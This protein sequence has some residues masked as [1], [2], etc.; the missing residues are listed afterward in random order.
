M[1]NHTPRFKARLGIF[2]AVG[3]LIFVTAIFIIGKQQNLF[4]PVFKISTNFL[5]VSGLQVGNNI[6]FSGINVGIVDNIKII[7]DSTV[8]VDMLVRKDVQQFIKADS[9]ASIGS[10]GIIGDRIIIITQGSTDSPLA[11]DGQHI[12]SKEPIETDEIMKSLKSSAE[13]AEV[14]TVQLAEIMMNINNGQG[15]LGRLIQD[16]VIAENVNMTIE[17]FRKSSEGLDETIE[18]TKKNLFAFM[19]SLQKTAAKTEVAS[20]QLGEIM[21]KIN[22]GEG[23]IGMLVQDTSLVNNIDATVIN[24][25]ESSIGLNEN[26]E[27]LKHNFLF[28]GY[29]RRKAKKEEKMRMEADSVMTVEND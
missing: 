17:N 9:Y 10:E 4:N 3:I 19:E 24:L 5:N 2:I 26:M 14:I 6:R 16:T 13:S 15:M 29:F 28:R 23:T 27:A 7:N 25:K 18:V 22:N 21:M 1:E 12:L 20:D 8:Q 11:E